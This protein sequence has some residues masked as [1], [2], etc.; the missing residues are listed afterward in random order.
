MSLIIFFSTLKMDELNTEERIDALLSLKNIAAGVPGLLR[1][2]NIL[3][4][5][6]NPVFD[7]RPVASILI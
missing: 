3:N 5:Q 6:V 7:W 2:R 1:N 4:L